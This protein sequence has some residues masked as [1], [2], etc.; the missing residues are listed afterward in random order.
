MPP[1][2]NVYNLITDGFSS[3]AHGENIETDYDITTTFTETNLRH[4]DIQIKSK[5]PNAIGSAS[6]L[7][8]LDFNNH[9]IDYEDTNDL[10]INSNWDRFCV[11]I[12]QQI[13]TYNTLQNYILQYMNN[14][15]Q[16]VEEDQFES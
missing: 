16:P 10:F 8:T 13:A 14:E 4:Y 12:E 1:M 9:L 11:I 3:M 15:D 7:L 6:L 5:N 2:K